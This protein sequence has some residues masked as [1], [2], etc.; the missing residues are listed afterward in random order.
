[1]VLD[2]GSGAA[3]WIAKH[4]HSDSSLAAYEQHF[5]NCDIVV[6]RALRIPEFSAVTSQEVVPDKEYVN[7][8]IFNDF[9]KPYLDG[10]FRIIGSV[11]ALHDSKQVTFGLHR[12]ADAGLYS[13]EE[14]ALITAMLPHLRRALTIRTRLI[15]ASRRTSGA[16]AVLD[17]IQYGV[18]ILSRRSEVILTNAYADAVLKRRDGLTMD[19]F[20]RLCAESHRE[21]EALGA[22]ITS[23][24]MNRNAVALRISRPSE[25]PSYE[26]LLS[27]IP[28]RPQAQG[29]EHGSVAVFLRDPEQVPT[30][31]ASILHRLYDL[32]P[33]EAKVA[34][35]LARSL[36]LQEIATE[37]G[38]GIET[39][40]SHLR[41]IFLKTGTARQSELVGLLTAIGGFTES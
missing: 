21:T 17:R 36:S 18:L 4:G 6:E 7:S 33:A 32:S 25:A 35:A 1:L 14:R 39:V 27:P 29:F 3:D 38:R 13:A 40:R 23:C 24:R 30:P 16:E 15:D 22:A 9:N 19:R 31:Q 10:A 37:S 41:S 5:C 26:L 2:R 11:F 34:V 20:G 12:N 28:A 8:P